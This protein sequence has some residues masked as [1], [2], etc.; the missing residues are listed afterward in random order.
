MNPGGVRATGFVFSQSSGGEPPGDVPYGEAFT[1]QPFGNSLVTMTLT[2]QQLKD[3][4]E[5]QFA[6]CV[7]T[8][9]P[10][11]IVN[12]LLLPSNGF[13]FTWG[14][15]RAACQKIQNISLTVGGV[16]ET[17]VQNG[18]EPT[19]EMWHHRGMPWC[20]VLVTQPLVA[21]AGC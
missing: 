11:Q 18:V 9:Q 4:L 20:H 15:T 1:V 13:K 10:A 19:G 14:F 8:G 21:R 6:G 3:V 12:R 5:Q 7:I 16:T 17:I 2:A